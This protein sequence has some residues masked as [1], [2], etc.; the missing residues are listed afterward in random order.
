MNRCGIERCDLAHS[1]WMTAVT[2]D[3]EFTSRECHRWLK[4]QKP[5]NGEAVLELHTYLRPNRGSVQHL[6]SSVAA[7]LEVQMVCTGMHWLVAALSHP[8]AHRCDRARGLA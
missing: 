5:A 2:P 8:G 4:A 7:L 3:R 1:W 6:S